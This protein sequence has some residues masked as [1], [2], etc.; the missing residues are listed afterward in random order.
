MSDQDE[1][2]PQCRGL[3]RRQFLYGSSAAA[4]ALTVPLPAYAD[5]AD[6]DKN[7]VVGLG[8]KPCRSSSSSTASR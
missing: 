2:P 1:R 8:R 5:K 4:T 6:Q 3:S 7:D